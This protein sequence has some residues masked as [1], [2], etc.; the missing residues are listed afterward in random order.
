[1]IGA[2]VR[3][4]ERMPLPDGL[5]RAAI[6][7]LCARTN[8]GLKRLD[9]RATP[10]F[11]R[12]MA[13]FAIAEHTDAAN[14]QHYEL[15]ASFFAHVLGPHMK[16]SSC[17]YA[18]GDTLASAEERAL[19]LT[20]GHARLRDGQR[21]LELGCGWGSLTLWMAERYPAAEI[22]AVSN[23]ASQRMH[24]L[25]RAGE[26]GLR[27]VTV[28]T[29]DINAFQPDGTFDRIVSVE[30]FE[31]LSNWRA[32]LQRMGSWLNRDGR[33]FLHVFSHETA[34]YRFDHRNQH[35]FIAQHFFTGGIMPSHSLIGEFGDCFA[36]ENQW[37]W[38]GQHYAATARD[39]LANY[40]ANH[41]CIRPVL[42]NVYGDDAAIWDRRWRLFFLATAGLF[43][44][45]GGKPWGVSHYLLRAT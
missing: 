6:H 27:N 30:M 31:H 15:P 16:Y 14:A 29:A 17:F 35:D 18:A 34:P 45:G 5:T 32:I 44:Y 9:A 8:Q 12:D 2:S 28:H 13:S 25:Q 23:S 42:A 21:I 4:A 24:I 38:S 39:W 33:A 36:I 41:A 3:L 10:D 7:L 11:A 20:A 26:R 22:V 19:A 40:D 37:R 1:M 43:G